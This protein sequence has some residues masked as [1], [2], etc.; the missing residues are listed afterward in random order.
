M[1][2]HD[3]FFLLLFPF[4]QLLIAQQQLPILKATNPVLSIKDGDEFMGNYWTLSPETKPDI[5]TADKTNKA[6][7]ITFYSDIDSISFE[8]KPME[9]YDFVILL[10]EKDSC[11]TRIESG[12]R[13]VQNMG[14]QM[15]PPDTIPFTLTPYNNISIQAVLN[16]VDTLHLMFHTAENSVNLTK[17]ATK[18]TTNLNLD[19]VVEADSWGGGGTTRYCDHNSLQIGKFHW[20]NIRIWED[21]NA[22]KLTDGKFGPNLFKDKIIEIDFDN[23]MLVIYSALPTIG[24]G[25]EQ[26]NLVF[27]R[28]FMYI[29]GQLDIGGNIYDN[30]FLIHSGF[31][32]T[33]LLDDNFVG[34]YNIGNKLQTI[35]ESELKDSFGNV[36]KTKK[37][38]LPA[39]S[40]GKTSFQEVP[41][42]FFDGAIG[43]QKMSVLGGDML[44]RFNLIIDLQQ[45]YIYLRANGLNGVPYSEG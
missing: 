37:A 45:A 30:D 10:N 14:V 34:T 2:K 33:I 20:D 16:K 25:Y 28:G 22:G 9:Q 42:G 23:S 17:E 39:L 41:I 8:V 36:L 11:Y 35:S 21:E 12:I 31:G 29:K 7:T 44:K 24:E 13:Q 3:F 19:G 15:T 27:K 4:A 1:T 6:K 18:K 32:G 5:Y 26:L 40:L 43:R 38:I